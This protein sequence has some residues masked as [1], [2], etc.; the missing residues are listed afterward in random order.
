MLPI[1]AVGHLISFETTF[2]LFL[3]AGM[4]KIDPRFAWFPGD[5][6]M[7]F[8]GISIVV[9]L[10]PLVRGAMFY[11]PGLQTVGASLLF[12]IWIAMSQLWSPSQ[13]YAHEKVT[14]VAVVILWCLTA[15]AVIIGSSRVRVWRFFWLLL[16]FG[17]VAS[18]DH[19]VTFLTATGYW[20]IDYYLTLGRLAGLVVVVAFAFWLRSPPLSV[21]GVFFL[22][23]F[24]LCGYVLLIGGGRGPTAAVAI[25]I[26]VPL[27]L[28]FRL[29]HARLVISK[30]IIP[31]LGLI[32]LLVL[33]L[34]LLIISADDSLRTLRR[35]DVLMN[36][37]GQSALD[38]FA[39][40]QAAVEYWAER[41]FFGQGV[42]AF[43]VLYYGIDLTRHPHNIILELLMELGLIGL[44]LFVLLVLVA[45]HRI[46]LQRLRAD[47]A[48][49]CA[50]M[51]CINTFVNAMSTGD[52]A[53]NRNVFV[54]L[55]LLAMR[56]PKG[57][58]DADSKGCS[59]D[60]GASDASSAEHHPPPA[61]TWG[62]HHS[63]RP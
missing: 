43:P 49:M 20:K 28:S 52:L 19:I 39:F 60:F 29:P 42:G 22:A 61:M 34:G 51:L 56:F 7:V 23:V 13:V 59:R 48:L 47:P 17:T 26:L 38:R 41:P 1:R 16:V 8:L 27:L 55:G 14:Y 21:S 54:M 58:L 33:A 45:G 32:A 25:S 3:F 31:T 15:S 46:R 30:R 6:T 11:R 35:F 50:A 44:A 62:A 40:W 37:R 12:V 36:E 4:Y 18:L 5:I 9:G 53:D 63:S 57:P 24:A 2:V 10:V